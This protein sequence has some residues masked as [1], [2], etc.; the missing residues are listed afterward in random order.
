MVDQA[1]PLDPSSGRGP[2]NPEQGQLVEARRRQWVVGDVGAS[3]FRD[4]FA[5]TIQGLVSLVS[6]DE[7][8]LGEELQVIWQLEPGARVLDRAGLPTI[9]GCDDADRLEAFLDAV[10]WGAATNA[11]RSFLQSPFRSGASIESYQLDPVVRAIDM[12][13]VNLLIADD[14]GLG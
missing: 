9:S 2:A 8:S 14:V 5:P 13:R 6:V 12:A 11:D 7:D 4:L 3:A 10:R 1:A